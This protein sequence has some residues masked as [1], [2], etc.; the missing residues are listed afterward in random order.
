MKATWGKNVVDNSDYVSVS[1]RSGS[2][3]NC[4]NLVRQMEYRGNSLVWTGLMVGEDELDTP[5]EQ[6]R[7]FEAKKELVLP[8][9]YRPP[10]YSQPTEPE[11]QASE[12]QDVP[13]SFVCPLL[14]KK[15]VP[16]TGK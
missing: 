6:L 13:G 10:Y 7:P 3:Y 16:Y 12:Y 5:Q 8:K 1:D 9:D 4:K 11:V 15:I 14:P 2:F